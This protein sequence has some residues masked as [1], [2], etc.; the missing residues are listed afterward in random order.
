[1]GDDY[2]PPKAAIKWRRQ[3]PYLAN[4][5]ILYNYPGRSPQPV[6]EAKPVPDRTLAAQGRKAR[7]LP[8]PSCPYGRE[9]LR[10][11]SLALYLH[12]AAEPPEAAS[13]IF[14]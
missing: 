2:M 14:H 5:V 13:K 1:M 9:G 10:E 6:R 4:A 7:R 3:A 8:Q 11:Y 12:R